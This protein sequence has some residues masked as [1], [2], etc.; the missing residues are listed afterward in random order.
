MIIV[1][2]NVNRIEKVIVIVREKRNTDGR[3]V[4]VLIVIVILIE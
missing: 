2:R 3:N 4:R 1:A